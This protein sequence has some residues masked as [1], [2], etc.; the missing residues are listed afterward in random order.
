MKR[1]ARLYKLNYLQALP[2]LLLAAACLTTVIVLAGCNRQAQPPVSNPPLPAARQD[3][4][5][6]L[7][8]WPWPKARKETLHK[9]ITHWVDRSSPDGTVLDLLEF[10]LAVNP[11]L[12]LELYD[13]DEDDA[14]PFDDS[15]D[16]Y[17]QGVGW[18]VHHLNA[19]GRGKVMAAWNGLFFTTDHRATSNP[20]G[21]GRHVAPV[22]LRGKPYF[23]VGNHRWTFGV[24]KNRSRQVFKT[25]HLPDFAT[26]A[27]EF[28]FAAAGAQCLIKE[29]R[30]LRLQ[31]FPTPGVTLPRNSV[32]STPQEAGY[33]PTVDHMKTSR[34]SMGWS[35]DSR[36]LYLLV[37]KEPD[38]ETVSALE[39]RHGLVM[40]G[41]WM[42]SD[43]QKFWKAKG[44]WGAV[45][46]DGGNVTQA[47]FLRPSGRYELLPA[48][49]PARLT[50]GPDMTNAP[51]GGSIM[52][53][54]VR[55]EGKP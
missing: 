27:R 29:G 4:P 12:R 21:I 50:F 28:T 19:S 53:W 9:G 52:Y 17:S 26:M 13:Q 6:A 35:K 8:S 5:S 23:N 18:A 3:V 36:K 11:T 51:G 45:N 7:T 42:V 2:Q 44:V 54:S 15:T 43:L 49:S 37:V 22:V 48:G 32:P 47:A 31:P 30:P 24:H 38:N 55:E 34:T 25:L 33:I 40:T 41:G 16:Y 39:L 1:L 10:D 20:H 14:H 46:V